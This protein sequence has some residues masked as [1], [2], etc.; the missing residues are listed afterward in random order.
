ML[1]PDKGADKTVKLGSQDGKINK[2][3]TRGKS[4]ILQK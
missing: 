2:L 3:K 1:M 4:G